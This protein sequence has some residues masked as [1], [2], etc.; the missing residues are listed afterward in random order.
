MAKYGNGTVRWIAGGL[1]SF[2]IVVLIARIGDAAAMRTMVIEGATVN[3]AQQEA[4][5]AISETNKRIERKV[6][7]ILERLLA[8][9]HGGS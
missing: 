5:A 2:G 7:R 3:A 4:I 9:D 6:D 8:G 1:F